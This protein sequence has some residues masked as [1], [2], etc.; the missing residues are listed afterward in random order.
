M[1]GYRFLLYVCVRGIDLYCKYVLGY[2]FVL[3]ICVRGIDFCCIYVLGVYI[4]V[5]YMC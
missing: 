4:Y 2:I 3:Y 1:L 5:A